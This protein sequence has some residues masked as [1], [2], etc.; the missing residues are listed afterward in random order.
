MAEDLVSLE[1]ERL[2]ALR[3][4]D[5]DRMDALHAP[6]YE[7]IN[8]AGEPLS[9]TT[10]L[11]ELE[12]GVLRYS[13]F[14]PSGPVRVRRAGDTAIVRYVAHIKIDRGGEQY[15]GH[16]WHTDYWERRGGRWQAVW[17]QA[18]ETEAPSYD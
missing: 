9:R 15:E 1:G 5:T 2:A 4:A 3:A 13:V 17:S 18:T 10:Y 11:G 7:L 8:P 6:E 12:S 14:E 16:F